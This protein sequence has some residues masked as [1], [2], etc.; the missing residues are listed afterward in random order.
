MALGEVIKKEP[1]GLFFYVG[2]FAGQKL[3]GENL[4]K[5]HV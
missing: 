5:I 2:V 1:W 4:F 3:Q